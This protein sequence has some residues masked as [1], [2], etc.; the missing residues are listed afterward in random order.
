MTEIAAPGTTAP[1]GSVTRPPSVARTSCAPSGAARRR[2]AVSSLSIPLY[3]LCR[4][5]L[6]RP[7]DRHLPRRL[8][9]EEVGDL[10]IVADIV[11]REV[12]EFA[13]LERSHLVAAPETVRRVDR[14]GADRLGER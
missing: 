7:A 6:Q 11:N 5:R 10:A 9:P 4:E 3:N 14:R 1:A 2:K 12:G 13:D 8:P